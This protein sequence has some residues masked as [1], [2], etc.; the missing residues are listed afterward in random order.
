MAKGRHAAHKGRKSSDPALSIE[1]APKPRRSRRGWWIA[2]L[3][4]LIFGLLAGGSAFAAYRYDKATADRIMPGVTVGGIDVGG[5]TRDEAITTVKAHLE[6]KLKKPLKV[7]A[8]GDTWQTSAADLNSKV[9]VPEAVDQA[10]A[11]TDDYSWTTRVYHRLAN[12]PVGAMFDV[13]VQFDKSVIDKFVGDV[14]GKVGVAPVSGGFQLQGGRLVYEKSKNGRELVPGKALARVRLAL[15]EGSASTKLP[16]RILKPPTN[17][18]EQK[19][20]VIDLSSK[21]LTLY[22]GKKKAKTYT[23]ATGAPGFPTPDGSFQIV[24]MRKNPTWVNPD[25]TGWGSSMPDSIPPG[26][27]NPLGTRAMNLNAPGI[28]IHGTSDIGSLGTAASHGC[29]RM[30]MSQVEELF[31]KVG[32]GTPVL[33]TR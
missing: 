20:I 1:R 8:A 30:A 17:E 23:V 29:I 25:P 11:I 24:E 6:A 19:T 26:P 2:G 15:R 28:R 16:V 3:S 5:M 9:L 12:R 14:G 31:E 21:Q 10:A 7:H 4:V 32:V 22:E 13:A 33:I 27:S 18:A